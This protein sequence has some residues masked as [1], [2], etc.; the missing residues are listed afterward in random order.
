MLS[1]HKKG[2]NTVLHFSLYILYHI[3]TAY[4]TSYEQISLIFSL[5]VQQGHIL[6]LEKLPMNCWIVSHGSYQL[7]RKTCIPWNH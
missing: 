2:E 1:V 5:I 3:D 7:N 6:A 4:R